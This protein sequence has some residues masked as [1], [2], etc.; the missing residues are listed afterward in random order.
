[1]FKNAW[2]PCIPDE[3]YAY[4][5]FC[6]PYAGGNA[7]LFSKW[8]LNIQNEQMV[9]VCPVQLPGRANRIKEK[10]FDDLGA[11]VKSLAEELSPYLNKPFLLFGHSLG[12]LIAYELARFLCYHDEMIRYQLQALCVSARYSPSVVVNLKK[13]SQLND[14]DFLNEILRLEGSAPAI[15]QNQQLMNMLIPTL[16]ADF[17]LS[18][19]YHYKVRET[20]LV[21]PIIGFAGIHDKL[22]PVSSMMTWKNETTA[23]YEQYEF[24][25]DHFFIHHFADRILQKIFYHIENKQCMS[26][27]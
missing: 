14:T 1:M 13:I 8:Q 24:D 5:L 20:L 25:G 23:F 16:K 26:L 7:S 9:Q 11:L 17:A 15:L 19:N 22:L 2:L 12:A 18:E 10:P 3:K 21:C 4:R 6:F 27:G